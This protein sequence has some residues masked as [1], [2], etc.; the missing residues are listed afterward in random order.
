MVLCGG[1]LGVVFVLMSVN[2]LLILVV[3]GVN[4]IFI[5]VGMID[6]LF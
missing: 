3:L 6:V 2:L 1:M 5:G 4:V